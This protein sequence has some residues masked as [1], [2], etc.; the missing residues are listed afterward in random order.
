MSEVSAYEGISAEDVQA[1]RAIIKAFYGEEIASRFTAS[2]VSEETV[3]QVAI[4]LS[5]TVDCS[6]WMDAVPSPKDLLMPAKSMQK[7]ALR[8]VRNAAKPFINGT[9][10]VTV[11][12]RQFRAAQFKNEILLSL[13]H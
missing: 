5:E 1:I 4:L 9:V 3:H 6:Q 13:K 7:W 11:T 8:L 12:C 10:G 2:S